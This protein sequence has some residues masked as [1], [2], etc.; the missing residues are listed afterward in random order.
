MPIQ[1]LLY[2]RSSLKRRIIY[3][4]LILLSDSFIG[5]A[6]Y[7]FPPTLSAVPKSFCSVVINNNNKD[8][9]IV[10]TREIQNNAL[11]NTNIPKK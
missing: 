6:S 11:Y 1:V 9:Y 3:N 4:V 7:L 2:C 8:F 10:H 5:V